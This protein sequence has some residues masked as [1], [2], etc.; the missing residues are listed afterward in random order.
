[1]RIFV[2]VNGI[3]M[4]EYIVTTVTKELIM[5]KVGGT[6]GTGGPVTKVIR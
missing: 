4:V 6:E 1:V 3:K 2:S 5:T